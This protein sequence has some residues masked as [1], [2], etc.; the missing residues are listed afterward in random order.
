M[1]RTAFDGR[2]IAN[3][4]TSHG[5]EPV[6]RTG[7]HLKLRY[8]NP[9]TDEVRIVTVPMKSRDRI[10]QGTLRSIAEQCGAKNFREWCH[11]IDESS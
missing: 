2:T 11:W 4:L 8:E 5:Y 7:S 3:V 1:V 10:P 6:D 9:D